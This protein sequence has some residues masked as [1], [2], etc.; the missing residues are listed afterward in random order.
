VDH[1]QVEASGLGHLEGGAGTG[2]RVAHLDARRAAERVLQRAHDARV[3]RTDRARQHHHAAALALA[4]RD[5]QSY[6]GRGQSGQPGSPA[7][8]R[9]RLALRTHGAAGWS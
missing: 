2:A 8:R 7:E 5:G 1:D 9:A 3:D 4:A 6:Q